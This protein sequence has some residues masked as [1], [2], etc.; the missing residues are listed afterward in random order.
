MKIKGISLLLA[1]VFALL[2]FG[3]AAEEKPAEIQSYAILNNAF[4]VLEEGNPFVERYNRITGEN[5]KARM[6]HGAPYFWGAQEDHLFAKEPEYV[7]VPAWQNSPSYYKAGTLYM[8]GFDCVGFVKWAWKETYGEEMPKRA[9]LF[10]DTEHQ[11]RNTEMGEGPL[12]DGCLDTIV[13]GDLLLLEHG[14]HHI[15]IY[16]GT[17]RM[18]GYTAEEVP[19][20][21]DQ[22]DVPLVIHCTTNAQISDRFADLIA[23]GL[24]KYHCATVTD[25]GVCISLL[26]NGFDNVPGLVHQQNQDTRYYTL[27]DGTWLTVLDCSNLEGYCWYRKQ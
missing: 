14:G 3:A 23:H 27:P 1:M 22:L 21:A 8:Y 11:I 24:P 2:C 20:L 12:W 4:T 26:V 16:V 7:V 9:W 10:K 5:V 6:S 17:L 25:G 18:Y 19:E 13:P 15:A